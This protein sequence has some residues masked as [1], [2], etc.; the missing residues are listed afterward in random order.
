LKIFKHIIKE[1]VL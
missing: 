1:Q